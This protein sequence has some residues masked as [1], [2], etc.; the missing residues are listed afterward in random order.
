MK[1][2]MTIFG[3]RPEAIK[4]A[5]LVLALKND[6]ELEPIVV[7][8]AQHREMLDQVLEI[9][10]ITPDYDLNIMK[11]GQTLSEV[12]SRVILGLEEVIKEAR[13]DMILVHGDTTTTFAGSLAA[14]YNEVA[15]GHVEAGLRTWQKYS[16]FPEEMNRQMTGTLADLHFAPTD[17][18][19]Q[20]LRNE[21]K[22]EDRIVIT[23]NT[24]IDALKTTVKSD[25]RSDIL[26]NAGERRVILLTAH[27]RENI[28]QPMHNIFSAIRR[29]VDEFE[30]VEVVYPMHK[31][32]KVRE[33]AAEH[34]SDHDRIQLI[35]PL[36]VIDFHNFASRSHFILTDSGGVQEEAPSLGKPVLVLR[37][38]TERPEGV[39]AGT[40]KLAGVEEEDIYQLTKSLL[41]DE[42]LYQSMSKASNPYGD[43]ETS[44]R[45]CEHIKYYF[46]LTEE[47]PAPFKV[48]SR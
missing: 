27:R 25:Y 18:A 6:P 1:K 26:D 23:G 7:V 24:A 37:D 40:L 14:F 48:E 22:P 13:P 11:A 44:Q 17:D 4:M 43:G 16:P 3:T 12:T 29:I 21:N 32:P 34:L 45:I 2:I 5:P 41:T 33:I 8:T 35:E 42:A 28:G 15:I 9:F 36:D 19:A 46:S 38:T 39:K 30:D 47:K 10:G 20:N 31:N